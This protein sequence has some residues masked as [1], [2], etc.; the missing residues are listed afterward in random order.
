MSAAALGFTACDDYEEVAPQSNPQET[1]MAVD[2]L[3]VALGGGIEAPI[4]LETA[5]TDS[6]EL[7]TTTAT[8]ALNEGTYFTYN[9]DIAA[10]ESFSEVQNVA[11]TNGKIA[12]TDLDNA[13]RALM[14]KT[15]NARTLYFR[16]I[17]Y[18]TDGTSKVLFKK[19]T[20]LA[21]TSQQ[22]TPVSLG[23]VVEDA[24]YIV[25]DSYFNPGWETTLVQMGH[26]EADVYDDA[27]FTA[28]IEVPADGFYIMAASD[29]QKALADP[30]NEFTYTFNPFV[31]E[32]GSMWYEGDL[33]YGTGIPFSI[34]TE[35]KFRVTIDMLERTYSL[36]EII[37][38]LYI[39][40]DFCGWDWNNATEMVPGYDNVGETGKFWSVV[41]IG[42][43]SGKGVKFNGV[44]EWDG[45]EFGYGGATLVSTVD[46]VSFVDDGGNIGV[47][48]SG[49]YI[50]GVDK[51][52]NGTSYDYTVNL[53]PA[54]VYVY[55]TCTGLGDNGWTDMP[56]WTF[57][58]PEAADG[59]FVSPVLAADGELRLCIH[60]M[61][62]DGTQ[63]IGDWWKSEFIFL[64]GKIAYRG[65]G[66]DQ[67]RVNVTAG[68]RVYL[69]FTTGDARAE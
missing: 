36:T 59:E 60:P 53:F 66:G 7:I 1:I 65:K 51:V 2:G 4:N 23:I 54:N 40:G 22:V 17:P 34:S 13:F 43:E 55:G 11:L 28:T 35:N 5:E 15:P 69:N 52:A 21:T 16:F 26:S 42:A 6:V 58:V 68:Q 24:Y 47:S 25:T 9:V 67:E 19:D 64:N 14:G 49:W 48:K 10:D 18:M 3:E 30:G 57:T 62:A 31:D 37:P 45:N 38:T 41:Y 63:W 33:Q 27:Q 39:I 50:I 12:N 44:R 32:K 61:N 29:V 20:Y 8:P 56:E 46:G